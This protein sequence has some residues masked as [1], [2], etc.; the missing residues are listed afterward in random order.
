M[1]SENLKLIDTIREQNPSK[2]MM[3]L[4]RRFVRTRDYM[5][6]THPEKISSKNTLQRDDL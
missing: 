4:G 2:K 1:I 3:T 5:H 6:C